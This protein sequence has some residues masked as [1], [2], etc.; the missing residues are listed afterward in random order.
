MRNHKNISCKLIINILLFFAG[1][2]FNKAYCQELK[3]MFTLDTI[4]YLNNLPIK[5]IHLKTN[6][7]ITDNDNEIVIHLFNRFKSDSF[8]FTVINKKENYKLKY[9]NAYSPKLKEDIYSSEASSISAND[10]YIVVSYFKKLAFF[11]I[12]KL[13]N[14]IVDIVFYKSFDVPETFKFLKLTNDGNLNCGFIYNRSRKNLIDNTLIISYKFENDTLTQKYILNPYFENV[15]FSHFSPNNWIASNSNYLAFSQTTKYEVSFYNNKGEYL[16]KINNPKANWVE[17]NKN[18]IENIKKFVPINYP[19]LM[20]DSL[21]TLNDN[22]IS[23]IEGIWF[24]S[25]D[26]F[27]LRYFHYDSLSKMKI[28]YFDKYLITSN[29]AILLDS[30]LNDGRFPIKI[31]E[32]VTKDN[33]DIHS[34]NYVNYFSNKKILILKNFANIVYLNRSWIEIK[35]D[36]EAYYGNNNPIPS[37]LIYNMKK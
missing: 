31:N 16:F 15:E 32:N 24:I 2:T 29:G 20:I 3:S 6:S 22:N 33:Y 4:V 1:N 12:I 27:F 13:N 10:N 5:N 30:N 11:K 19:G 21:R 35:K 14:M 36:E 7:L 34:W 9:I 28:R 37:L 17:I 18:R 26:I 8:F 25:N 23:R